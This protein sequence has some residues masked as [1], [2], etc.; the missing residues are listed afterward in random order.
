MA[1]SWRSFFE[2]VYAVTKEVKRKGTHS[3]PVHVLE[4]MSE[5]IEYCINGVSRIQRVIKDTITSHNDEPPDY[6][7]D[8]IYL[9]SE[10]HV[11]L[12]YLHDYFTLDVLG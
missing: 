9:Y 11:L 8:C 6:V 7:S 1:E 10:I 3:S 4:S 5:K 12:L 2:L